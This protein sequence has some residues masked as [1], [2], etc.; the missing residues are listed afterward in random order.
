VSGATFVAGMLAGLAFLSTQKAIY[1]DLALGA[2][3]VVNAA[4]AVGLRSAITSGVAL[5]SGWAL[6]VGVFCL[7]YGGSD[8]FGV[9]RHLILGPADLAAVGGELYEGLGRF[10]R[11]TL[12][13]NPII[14]ALSFAGLILALSRVRRLSPAQRVAAVFSVVIAVLVFLHSQP[15]PYLFIWALPFLVLWIPMLGDVAKGRPRQVGIG[16]LAV[17][18]VFSFARNLAHFD[19]DNRAQLALIAEAESLI[20][21]EE[22]YFDGIGLLPSR[23]DTPRRWLDARGVARVLG[24][25]DDLMAAL[26]DAPPVLVIESYRTDALGPDFANWLNGIYGEVGPGLWLRGTE[27]RRDLPQRAPLFE[28]V[29]TR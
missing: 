26:R 23:N 10:V 7:I 6:A 25:Q 9:L 3:L 24:G 20:G 19:H 4:L 14:Y 27:A 16:I 2:G 21:P 29:Y 22:S 12:V 1:F 28:G 15:W 13:R 8:L 18:V 5:V 17:A 11:Q